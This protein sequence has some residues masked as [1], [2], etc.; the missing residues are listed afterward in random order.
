MK[1][2]DLDIEQ[3][4]GVGN[5]SEVKLVTLKPEVTKKYSLKTSRFALQFFSKQLVVEEWGDFLHCLFHAKEAWKEL[6]SQFIVKLLADFEDNNFFYYVLEL[7]D[8]V[9]LSN[10][11][12]DVKRLPE[13]DSKFCAAC[14]VCAFEHIHSKRIAVRDVKVS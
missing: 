9:D 6:E 14:I 10:I 8:K 12:S 3:H 7:H 1:I 2:S 4:L 13:N 11:L 5:F